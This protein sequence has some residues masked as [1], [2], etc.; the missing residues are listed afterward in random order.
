VQSD[1]TKLPHKGD[2]EKNIL[3]SLA[4]FKE[5]MGKLMEE[6]SKS[7]TNLC[8]KTFLERFQRFFSE[9]EKLPNCDKKLLLK[10]LCP[11][12]IVHADFRIE[13]KVNPVFYEG[14]EFIDLESEKMVRAKKR[15]LGWRDSN[16][17]PTD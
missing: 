14:L 9:F 4:F 1:R 2:R 16:S 15:W 7:V 13:M 3:M 8:D 11:K 6:R 12:I 17:R 5:N 10:A